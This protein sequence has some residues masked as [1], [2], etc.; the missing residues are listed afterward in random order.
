MSDIRDV[1]LALEGEL[2]HGSATSAAALAPR[3]G[4]LR[5]RSVGA[6]VAGAL[7]AIVVKCARAGR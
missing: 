3:A 6:V 1:R 7:V 2:A 4:R 5:R